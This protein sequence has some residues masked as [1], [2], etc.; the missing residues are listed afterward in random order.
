MLLIT[1]VSAKNC[2]GEPSEEGA[3]PKTATVAYAWAVQAAPPATAR[4]GLSAPISA[5]IGAKQNTHVLRTGPGGTTHRTLGSLVPKP[6][7]VRQQRLRRRERWAASA[8]SA[9]HLPHCG[10]A[11]F[12][13]ETDAVS[14]ESETSV[15]GTTHF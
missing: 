8:F 15:A 3:Q 12:G 6:T 2:N 13:T 5:V 9:Q 4:A 7:G 14:I 10:V 1:T 11:C